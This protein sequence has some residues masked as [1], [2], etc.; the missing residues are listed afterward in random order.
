LNRLTTPSLAGEGFAGSTGGGSIGGGGLKG[1][2]SGEADAASQPLVPGNNLAAQY[3]AQRPLQVLQVPGAAGCTCAQCTA[4]TEVAAG[5]ASAATVAKTTVTTPAAK[6]LELQSFAAV[7]KEANLQARS[8]V[9][10]PHIDGSLLH[11]IAVAHKPA[12][13]TVRRGR[14]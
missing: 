14:R 11:T 13:T 2:A 6:P 3:Y 9:V 12:A 4:I 8:K 5:R 7:K 10:T 1:S